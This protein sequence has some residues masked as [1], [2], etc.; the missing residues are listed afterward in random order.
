MLAINHTFSVPLRTQSGLQLAKPFIGEIDAVYQRDGK[1]LLIDWKT[2]A[3]RW[4]PCQ[5]QKNMQAKAML[6]GYNY[7][8]GKSVRKTHAE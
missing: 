8:N 1:P 2:S 4:S 3:R 6:Y 7:E 5:A